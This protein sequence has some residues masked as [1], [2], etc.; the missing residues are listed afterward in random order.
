MTNPVPSRL[1]KKQKKEFAQYGA[2]RLG[3][4]EHEEI[5]EEIC[6]REILEHED[7]IES[8]AAKVAVVVSSCCHHSAPPD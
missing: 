2:E 3:V 1:T 8:A 7:I 4:D 6:R 5:V